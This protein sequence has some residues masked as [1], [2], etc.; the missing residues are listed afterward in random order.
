[1][2]VQPRAP[3][4]ESVRARSGGGR[5]ATRRR[6]RASSSAR[7]SPRPRCSR[8][9]RQLGDPEVVLVL[10]AAPP[11]RRPV[12]A[13]DRA[14]VRRGEPRAPQR[15]RRPVLECPSPPHPATRANAASITRWHVAL[16]A[17]RGRNR[18]SRSRAAAPVDRARARARCRRSSPPS[19]ARTGG[20]QQRLAGVL[21]LRQG[22]AAPGAGPRRRP[23]VLRPAQQPGCRSRARGAT[24]GRAR[25]CALPEQQ[26]DGDERVAVADPDRVA[27]E[28]HA[29]AAGTRRRSHP[30]WPSPRRRRGSRT[31]ATR[32]R[33]RSASPGASGAVV[34]R[35]T[36]SPPA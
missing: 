36:R 22:L 13:G 29:R 23:G 24:A 14:D 6:R 25:M 32:A 27:P 3:V 18:G 11:P 12:A 17:A 30:R 19:R 16:V 28:V 10:D 7:A 4:R 9:D 8:R 15:L 5:T 33:P 34:R 1:M 20:L 21:V 26:A 35:F 31:P 2:L